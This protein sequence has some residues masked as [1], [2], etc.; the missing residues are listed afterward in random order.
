MARS[1]TTIAQPATTRILVVDDHPM[2]REGISNCLAGQSDLRVCCSAADVKE[3]LQKIRSV[4]PDLAIIDISL[5]NGNGIDL[6]KEIRTRNARIKMLVYSMFDESAYAERALRAGALGYVNKQ[7]PPEKLL[8]GI[9]Q[10]L[11]GRI[12]V[13]EA[14]VDRVIRRSVAGNEATVPTPADALSNRE[15]EIFRLLGSGSSTRRVAEQLHISVRTVE[16]HR[17]NIK[18]KLNIRDASELMRHAVE[19]VLTN[20]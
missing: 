20:H 5:K 14:M 11:D 4:Q 18:Q 6:I 2:V 8:E 13:S 10:V 12:Y 1:K 17:E 7:E 9:R 15:L 16:T 19:W 3:A